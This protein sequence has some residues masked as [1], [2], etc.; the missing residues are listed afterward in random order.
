MRLAQHIALALLLPTCERV[1]ALW[2][3]WMVHNSC[4]DQS[5]VEEAAFCELPEVGLL[6]L[7]QRVKALRLLKAMMSDVHSS[8]AAEVRAA[9]MKAL[10]EERGRN[11]C[12][13]PKRTRITLTPSGM[14]GC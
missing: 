4:L 14:R 9:L 11:S 3:L 6:P 7:P 13:A 8:E 2:G 10:K 12:P 1:E 5:C